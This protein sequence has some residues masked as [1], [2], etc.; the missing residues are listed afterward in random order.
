MLEEDPDD[1]SLTEGI[2][3]ELGYES[4]FRYLTYS[5]EL[6]TQLDSGERP[7]LILLD[8][9]SK[10]QSAVQVLGR[11]KAHPEHGAIPVVVLGESCSVPHVQECY[12]L[13]ANS[14]IVKPDSVERTRQKIRTFL[15][16]WLQVVEL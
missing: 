2:A 5:Q 6:F 4:L 10:P 8:Y 7:L 16:Y 1:R 12:R 3:G 11:L 13:G 15:E 9:N 14:F